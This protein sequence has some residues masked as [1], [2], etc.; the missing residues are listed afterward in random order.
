MGRNRITVN[1]HGQMSKSETATND[2]RQAVIARAA[3]TFGTAEKA[4]AWLDRPNAAL[5][6]CTPLSLIGSRDGALRVIS[7]LGRIDHGLFS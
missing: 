3:E 4:A 2:G 7:V 1:A 5:G 6:G